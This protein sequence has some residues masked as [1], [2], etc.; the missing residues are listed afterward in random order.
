MGLKDKLKKDGSNFSSLNG[1][2]AKIKNQ[3]LSVLHDEYSLNG[4]PHI[5]PPY[6]GFPKPSKL[7][8]NG[9]KPLAPNSD[10]STKPINNSFQR[11]TY[12]NSA[13]DEGVGRI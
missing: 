9:V 4:E 13:P 12:K 6:L 5:E 11:G 3:K 2:D 10:P 1:S 8:L 7:D